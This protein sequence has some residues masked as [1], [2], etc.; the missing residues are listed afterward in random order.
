MTTVARQ[1]APQFPPVAGSIAPFTRDEMD[2]VVDSLQ[3]H[4][5]EWVAL[6]VQKR[7]ALLDRLMADF[8]EIAPRWVAASTRAKGIAGDSPLVGE[9]WASGTWPVLKNLRQLRQA[10]VRMARSARRSSR[11]RSMTAS[12]SRA[13]RQRCEWNQE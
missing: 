8:A 4:K 9:E 7:I 10:L 6:P 3:A 1:G 5:D 13:S 11:K 12:S 2:A